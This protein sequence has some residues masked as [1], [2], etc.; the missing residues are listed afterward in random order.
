MPRYRANISTGDF[1]YGEVVDID[2]ELYPDEIEAGY[3][4]ELADDDPRVPADEPTV[5]TD[6]HPDGTLVTEPHDAE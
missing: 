1:H 2:P 6:S 3:L 5:V 4:V